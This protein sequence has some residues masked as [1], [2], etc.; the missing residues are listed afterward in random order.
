MP[1]LTFLL[2]LL[3]GPVF[4]TRAAGAA[5]AEIVM[6]APMALFL[7]VDE[8]Y[9]RFLALCEQNKRAVRPT[10][11]DAETMIIGQSEYSGETPPAGM[12]KFVNLGH[13][14][15]G[16]VKDQFGEKHKVKF[17]FQ[18]EAR[19]ST[20]RRFNAVRTYNATWGSSKK[21]SSLREDIGNWR[22][23]PITDAEVRAGVDLDKVAPRG[24]NGIAYMV[25]KPGEN[26]RV[27]ANIKGLMP[28]PDGDTLKPEEDGNGATRVDRQ[29]ADAT[30]ALRAAARASEDKI[31]PAEAAL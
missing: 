12:Q 4:L 21:P 28:S 20:G 16:I 2:G 7:H 29:Q 19:D 15:L 25:H 14:D 31:D 6:G 10:E 11:G 17:K 3:V 1:L 23:T 18:L 22:G 24:K 8:A 30:E 5:C 26:G 13:E 9:D 27:F